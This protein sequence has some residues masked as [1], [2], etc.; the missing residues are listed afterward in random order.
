M[1]SLEVTLLAKIYLI[2]NHFVLL[3]I[4]DQKLKAFS[5][6]SMGNRPMSKREIEEMKKREQEQAAAQV[7]INH[8]LFHMK[9]QKLLRSTCT[10]IRRIRGNFRRSTGQQSKQDLDQSWYI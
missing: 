4:A 9:A 8:S 7:I 10:G 2:L 3:Q 1:I 5:I 6:G